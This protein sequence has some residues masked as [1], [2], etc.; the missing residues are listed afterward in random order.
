[1]GHGNQ[2]NYVASGIILL[3]LM[4]IPLTSTAETTE[5]G[6]VVI[7]N[8]L[9]ACGDNNFSDRSNQQMCIETVLY[10]FGMLF[11]VA[12]SVIYIVGYKIKSFKLKDLSELFRSGNN[13][14][15]SE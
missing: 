11:I 9:V 5:V 7:S 12:I 10:V 13:D 15:E 2:R 4:M 1:M 6:S 14:N 3:L 8:Y